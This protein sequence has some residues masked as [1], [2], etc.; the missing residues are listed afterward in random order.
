MRIGNQEEKDLDRTRQEN[1]RE[2][3]RA[4][5]TGKPYAWGQEARSAAAAR[6]KGIA[7]GRLAPESRAFIKLHLKIVK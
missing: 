5:M 4:E 2:S 1:R 6:S 3:D 7:G